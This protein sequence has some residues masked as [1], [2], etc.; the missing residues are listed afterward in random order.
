[1]YIKRYKIAYSLNLQKPRKV[2][3]LIVSVKEPRI[4]YKYEI[5][6][7]VIVHVNFR[8]FSQKGTF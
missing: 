2:C 6:K 4:M 8:S 7:N 5:G 3:I 1:M